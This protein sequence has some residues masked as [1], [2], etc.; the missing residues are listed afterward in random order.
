MFVCPPRDPPLQ[1]EAR[2]EVAGDAEPE[3]AHPKIGGGRIGPEH[4]NEQDGPKA[5][6]DGAREAS[7]EEGCDRPLV[8]KPGLDQ[9]QPDQALFMRVVAAERRLEILGEPVQGRLRFAAGAGGG[10]ARRSLVH[11]L[12]GAPADVAASLQGAGGEHGDEARS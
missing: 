10:P 11:A 4:R 9:L 7:R 12:G 3:R 6:D 8:E 2:R 1:V 5:Q